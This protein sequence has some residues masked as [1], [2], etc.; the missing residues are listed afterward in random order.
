MG[1]FSNLWYCEYAAGWWRS[2]SEAH[3][4]IFLKYFLHSFNKHIMEISF[5]GYIGCNREQQFFAE[6]R[7]NV[8]CRKGTP[9]MP[10]IRTAARAQQATSSSTQ[11]MKIRVSGNSSFTQTLWT[12]GVSAVQM[13][14][15]NAPSNHEQILWFDGIPKWAAVQAAPILCK[16]LGSALQEVWVNRFG[17]LI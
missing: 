17:K 10:S 5:W 2:E 14:E 7:G 1:P 6:A 4:I 15:W 8:L 16:Q 9:V 13:G 12:L 11:L 3:S